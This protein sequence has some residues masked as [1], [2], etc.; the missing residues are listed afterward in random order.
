[1]KLW[2]TVMPAVLAGKKFASAPAEANEVRT[3]AENVNRRM[4]VNVR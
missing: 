3:L 1:M 4:L 2:S